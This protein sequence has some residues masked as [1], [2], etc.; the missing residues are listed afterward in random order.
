MKHMGVNTRFFMSRKTLWVIGSLTILCTFIIAAYAPLLTGE[1]EFLGDD[2]YYIL[3]N[4]FVQHLDFHSLS[5]IWTKHLEFD[6]FPVTLTSFAL[7]CALWGLDPR[8]FHITNIIIFFCIGITA[9]SLSVI[10]N[11]NARS[12]ETMGLYV[13]ALAAVLLMLLHPTQVESVAGISNRKELLYVL[14]GLLAFRV[15]I[16]E[17]GRTLLIILA[18]VCMTLAQLS[19]GTGIVLPFVLLAYE[20]FYLKGQNSYKR[21]FTRLAP[22]FIISGLIFFCQFSVARDSGVIQSS[23]AVSPGMWAGGVLRTITIAAKQCVL[24]VKLT[25]DYDIKWP[26]GL[27]MGS[28]W[29]VPLFIGAVL[30][31][32]LY[33]KKYA[34]LFLSLFILIPFLP[35]SNIVPLKHVIA[36][37]LVYYDHYLL[38]PLAAASVFLARWF[39][40]SLPWRRT[41]IAGIAV[42]AILY[43]F[44][45]VRLS[46]S[47]RSGE[48]LYKRALALAPGISRPYYFLG[49]VYLDKGRYAEALGLFISAQAMN[50]PYPT[51]DVYQWIGEAY[52]LL[53]RYSEAEQYYRL[54][55]SFK[56]DDKSSLQNLSSTL[57]MLKRDEEARAVIQRLLSLYPADPGA[58]VNLS[59][60]ERRNTGKGAAKGHENAGEP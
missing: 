23:P 40:V 20:L 57:I 7:D 55:L 12:G 47:W 32:L 49:K 11:R 15:Y 39:S 44:Q 27:R 48:R 46:S 14:F 36:G 38:F 1:S 13:S 58:L 9:F 50:Q 17:S 60:L 33:R 31:L 43:V 24:P 52:A 6:Y 4:S 42:L 35:Y 10:M 45:D 2:S 22:F 3:N 51:V 28:E 8:M 59:I 26:D 16:S 56:P 53:G 34:Y 18:L 5:E 54:H 30:A 41:I 25:Y 29:L 37:N 19:K 21:I